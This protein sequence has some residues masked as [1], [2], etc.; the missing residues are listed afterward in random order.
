MANAEKDYRT[1][2]KKGRK[3]GIP[4][5]PTQHPLETD[6]SNPSENSALRAMTAIESSVTP[7]QY[8]AEV[9]EA[10][11][12]AATGVPN[13]SSAAKGPKKSSA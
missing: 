1:A 6:G 3:S 8:P 2:H 12:A 10:Q 9:R 4:G 11:V 5:A 7:E 13:G